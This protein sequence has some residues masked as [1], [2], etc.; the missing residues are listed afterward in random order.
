MSAIMLGRVCDGWCGFRDRRAWG[1][2]LACAPLRM[3]GMDVRARYSGFAPYMHSGSLARDETDRSAQSMS[4]C[5]AAT[6][7]AR[8]GQV[9]Q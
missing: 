9:G 4:V 3:L 6:L 5:V 7:S 1:D 2:A 8:R